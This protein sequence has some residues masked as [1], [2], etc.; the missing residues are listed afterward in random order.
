M[1]NSHKKKKSK[2][3]GLHLDRRI[4]WHKHIFV[5][6]KQL[7]IILTKIYWLLGR[8]SKLSTNNKLLLHIAILKP[9][10][11]YGLQ[12]WGTASTCNIN[13]FRTFP[14]ED[15]AH[16]SGPTL[17]VPNTIISTELQISAVKEEIQRYS[18]QYS[19]RLTAHPNDLIANLIGL[20]HNR[21]LLR[22]LPNDLS[23]R[24]LV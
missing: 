3:L 9:I 21:R 19:A 24:F 22:N 12:L 10:W 8:K 17:L 13:I 1:C 6:R 18:S 2:Y 7:G 11:T 15:L 20:P 4:T 16:N 23:T 5:K 14:V